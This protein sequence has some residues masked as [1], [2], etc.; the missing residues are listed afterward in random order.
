LLLG[1]KYLGMDQISFIQNK[2]S[3]A[4]S[5]YSLNNL[6]TV[7]IFDDFNAAVA[8]VLDN[9]GY[10]IDYVV[11]RDQESIS[12]EEQSLRID[13]IEALIDAINEANERV[14]KKRL[15]TYYGG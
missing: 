8:M 4:V 6:P 9:T 7:I 12:V 15:S 11:F 13:Q 2:V 3:V 14:F 5:L 10:K 1:A